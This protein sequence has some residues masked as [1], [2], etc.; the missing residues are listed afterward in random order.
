MDEA[1]G[2]TVEVDD[3]GTFKT[4]VKYQNTDITLEALRTL[5]EKLEKD[6]LELAGKISDNEEKIKQVKKVLNK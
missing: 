2:S 3:N 1:K 5:I 6:N 4:R